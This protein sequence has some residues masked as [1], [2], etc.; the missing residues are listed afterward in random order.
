MC[1]DWEEIWV[2]NTIM[3]E[4]LKCA[5][6][7]LKQRPSDTGQ[8]LEH[9]SWWRSGISWG[10]ETTLQ[11]LCGQATVHLSWLLEPSYHVGFAKLLFHSHV[12]HMWPKAETWGKARSQLQIIKEM[13][14][15][16]W[17]VTPQMLLR[18]LL[19]VPLKVASQHFSPWYAHFSTI[20]YEI[21]TFSL[22]PWLIHL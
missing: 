6:V 8:R 9:F 15:V 22:N 3:K 1:K 4:I 18:W 13:Y 21:S 2:L 7:T 19:K 20:D 11:L 14:N 17:G 10:F 16:G 5:K 12:F